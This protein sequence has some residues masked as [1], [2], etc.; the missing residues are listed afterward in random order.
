M[1]DRT[2]RRPLISVMNT[3]MT[4]KPTAEAAALSMI[5]M[6][7]AFPGFEETLRFFYRQDQSLFNEVIA[8]WPEGVR[9]YVKKPRPR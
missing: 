6:A 2:G 5:T 3:P 7:D 8:P 4:N 9:N 1:P